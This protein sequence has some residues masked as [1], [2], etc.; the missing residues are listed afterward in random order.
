MQ[1]QTAVIIWEFPHE[2]LHKN[3][4]LHSFSHIHPPYAAKFIFLK[5]N[6]DSGSS[7]RGNLHSLPL[8]A[9]QKARLLFGIQHPLGYRTSDI[10]TQTF[11]AYSFNIYYALNNEK[12]LVFSTWSYFFSLN[13]FVLLASST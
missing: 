11:S 6:P 8:P 7:V 1:K 10:F 12:K 2:G 13:F 4:H 5:Y 3:K 9:E